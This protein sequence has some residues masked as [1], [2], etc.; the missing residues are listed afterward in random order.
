MLFVF[1]TKGLVDSY[2]IGI[3]I[4][5]TISVKAKVN[6]RSWTEHNLL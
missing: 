6:I 4:K 5:Y 2:N 3:A 1:G